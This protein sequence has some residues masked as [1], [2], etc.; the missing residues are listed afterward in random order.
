M[1]WTSALCESPCLSSQ[2]L[3]S[4]QPEKAGA[5]LRT[6]WAGVGW[7]SGDSLLAPP[8]VVPPLSVPSPGFAFAPPGRCGGWCGVLWSAAIPYAHS[9]FSECAQV[10]GVSPLSF[11]MQ[12]S[13]HAKTASESELSATAAEL[14]Q[15][16]MLTVR[17]LW[18]AK[19]G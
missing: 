6:C 8:K 12:T 11:C 2:P 17:L 13:P 15:D 10:G 1:R 19:G 16:Y 18:G 4:A 9:A 14:L 3:G 7:G 5:P